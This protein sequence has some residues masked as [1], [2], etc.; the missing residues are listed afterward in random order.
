[1]PLDGGEKGPMG[2]E[3]DSKGA[4]YAFVLRYLTHLTPLVTPN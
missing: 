2:K 1:M 3:Q 4:R